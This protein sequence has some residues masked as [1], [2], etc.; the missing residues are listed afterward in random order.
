MGSDAKVNVPIEEWEREAIEFH[1]LHM[2][3]EVKV[4][5]AGLNLLLKGMVEMQGRK[6]KSDA[7]AVQAAL[8]T[9]AWNTMYCAYSLAL[10]AYY[11]QGLNLLRAPIEDWMAYWYLR[12]FPQEHQKFLSMKKKTPT[13]RK[14]LEK[15]EKKYGDEQGEGIRDWINRL[16]KFSHVDRMGVL[17]VILNDPHRLSLALGPEVDGFGFNYKLCTEQALNVIVPHAEALDDFRRLVG[18]APLVGFQE[19]LGRVK[20]WQDAQ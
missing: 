10:R 7:E 9:R 11:S 5:T 17:M 3:D 16:H 1:V 6:V 18:L 13:F 2:A 4:W 12:A 20:A 8:L 14:M 15:I 19:Y